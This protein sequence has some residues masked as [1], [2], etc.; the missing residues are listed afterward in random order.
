MTTTDQRIVAANIALSLDGR[1]HGAGGPGD[2][3]AIIPYVSTETARNHLARLHENATTGVLGRGNAEGF[4]GYWSGVAVD[5]NA[6]PRDRGYA[7]WLVDTEKVIFS[8]TVTEMPWEHV[9][10]VNAPASEVIAELKTVGTGEILVNTSPTL[11][12]ALLADDLVDRL[13][14]LITPEIAGG[15]ERLFVDGLPAT[16]WRLTSQQVGELG[17]MALVY[18]R[19]R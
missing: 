4:L 5:D 6:D 2:M 11:T 10:V 8:T 14:L 18:D 15:G 17:E 19:V 7:K 16:H 3:A 12:K 13:Y 9:R 1:Y